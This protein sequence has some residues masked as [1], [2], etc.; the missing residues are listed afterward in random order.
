MS[1][2]ESKKILKVAPVIDVKDNDNELVPW[3]KWDLPL[4][5]N[6]ETSLLYVS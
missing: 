6:G 4:W 1:D 2:R 3:R 5:L